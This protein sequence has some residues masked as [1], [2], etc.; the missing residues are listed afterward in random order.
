M[1]RFY[2]S[3]LVL[4]ALAGCNRTPVVE[5]EQKPDISENLINANKT[6]AKSEETSIDG[7]V[8]RRGWDMNRLS[9]GARVMETDKGNGKA[10]GYEDSVTFHYTLSTLNG[11]TIYQDE[12]ESIVVGRNQVP[13]GLD[14]ALL[15]LHYGSH[16]NVIIP[17]EAGYGVVGDGDRIP[18]RTVLIYDLTIET[19]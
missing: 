2:I 10:I 9:C 8:A 12:T 16:A 11:K 7:Y 18:A 13:T 1:K 19:K 4:L 14:A 17:S 5:V 15:T 6:I 3:F